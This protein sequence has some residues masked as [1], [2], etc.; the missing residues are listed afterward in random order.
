MKLVQQLQL[1]VLGALVLSACSRSMKTDDEWKRRLTPEQYE[2]LREKGTERAFSGKYWNL[3]D[4]GSYVCAGCGAELFTS[5]DKFDSGCGWPSY[6]RAVDDGRILEHQDTSHGMLR[7]EVV[8]ANCGGHLGHVF[9]DGPAPTGRRY[10][11][12]SASLDFKKAP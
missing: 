10:C 1:W 7:T 6:T 9:D 4:D 3:K 8:C 2:V 12:N 11:I 5:A